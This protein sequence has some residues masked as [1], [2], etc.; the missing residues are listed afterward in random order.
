MKNKLWLILMIL[1]A[2]SLG[3]CKKNGGSSASEVTFDKNTSYAIGLSV[4]SSL[5]EGLLADGAYPNIEEFIK[6]MRAG[7]S[8]KQGRFDV[9][10][11]RD[12]IET[13]FDNLVEERN[14]GLVQTENSYLAEN[15]R[16]PG[17]ITTASGLQY[18]VINEGDGPKPTA[19]DKVRVHY[20]GRF[21]NDTV[22]DSSK[23]RG[24][25][26]EFDLNWIIPGWAEGLQLM[27]VGSSYKFYI[28]SELG[29]GKDGLQSMIPPYSTLIFD[30]ELIDI[31]R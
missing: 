25:P 22:F 16:K 9:A 7:I 4:G 19:Q 23:A 28:P 29:Y 2:I 24:Y 30:V 31:V 12:M 21:T 5:R 15:A 6:G 8:G 26:E 20:E 3:S 14:A 10:E 1:A 13:A 18:E 27:G 17:I 11:A